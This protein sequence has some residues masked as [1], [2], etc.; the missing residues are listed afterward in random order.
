MGSSGKHFSSE[1]LNLIIKPLR[2]TDMTLPGIARRMG[3][4]RSGIAYINRGYKIRIYNGKRSSWT[5]DK[6]R[7]IDLSAANTTMLSRTP[8]SPE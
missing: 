4:T 1:E 7:T 8:H 3:C 2:E 6:D 5:T